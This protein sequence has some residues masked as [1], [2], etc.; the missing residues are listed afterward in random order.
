MRQEMSTPV[1]VLVF[2]NQ[3]V[4]STKLEMATLANVQ[5]AQQVLNLMLKKLCA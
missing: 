3:S 1:S 2:H 5:A 4:V